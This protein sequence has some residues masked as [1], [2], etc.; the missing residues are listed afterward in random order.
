MLELPCFGEVK[1]NFFL[2]SDKGEKE[3]L[4][5]MQAQSTITPSVSV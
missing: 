2:I 3:V 1:K 4:N 5:K